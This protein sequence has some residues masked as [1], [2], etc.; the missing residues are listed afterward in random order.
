MKMMN[1]SIFSME[2][3]AISLYWKSKVSLYWAVFNKETNKLNLQYQPLV[4]LLAL[5][6]SMTS[7]CSIA[8]YSPSS[9]AVDRSI[10]H[11]LIYLSSNPNESAFIVST[12]MGKVQEISLELA[13]FSGRVELLFGPEKT[14]KIPVN[15]GLLHD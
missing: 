1:F 14:T 13:E 12:L 6:R 3:S 8:A 9:V 2:R 5:S 11:Q 7:L 4:T 10:R 15:I